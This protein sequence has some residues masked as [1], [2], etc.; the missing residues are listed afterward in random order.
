MDT[1]IVLALHNLADR[2]A[3]ANILVIFFGS[4][5]QYAVVGALLL[6]PWLGKRR[7]PGDEERTRLMAWGSIATA[8]ISRLALTELVRF[9][10][11]RPRPF[12]ALHFI[13]LIAHETSASFPSGH[14]AFFFGIAWFVYFR[15]R[16][17]GVY[18]FISAALIGIARIAAGIHYPTDIFGGIAVGLLSAWIAG[19]VIERT[20]LKTLL[21]NSPS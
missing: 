13:P 12:V 19:L 8:L 16:R 11:N 14:A 10:Y 2:S 4:W 5:L 6:R 17:L 7:M 15:N 18:F 9:F 1:S 3:L 20:K 21:F